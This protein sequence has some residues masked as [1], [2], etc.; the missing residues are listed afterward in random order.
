ML[1]KKVSF[2]GYAYMLQYM[3]GHQGVRKLCPC[4]IQYISITEHLSGCHRDAFVAKPL[5]RFTLLYNL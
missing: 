4:L 5:E 2:V 3:C 1:T